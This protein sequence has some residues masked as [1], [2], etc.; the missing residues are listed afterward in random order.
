MYLFTYVVFSF[1]CSSKYFL[2]PF[3]ISSLTH[4]LFK[5][6]L[7]CFQL[8]V[9]FPNFL[10]LLAFNAVV[11]GEC[12][13]CG[14]KF[15]EI[16]FVAWYIVCPGECS[17][18]AWKECI[19]CSSWWV[20]YRCHL[21]QADRRC[22]ESPPSLLAFCLILLSLTESGVTDCWLI[23]PSRFIPSTLLHLFWGCFRGLFTVSLP[24]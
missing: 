19:F 15:M 20:S 11:V 7:F 22:F 5:I 1:S 8:F 16:C 10:P 13:L 17:M 14:F 4:E 24:H 18:C 3:V 23:F 21:G 2:I 12:T 9:N 6:K